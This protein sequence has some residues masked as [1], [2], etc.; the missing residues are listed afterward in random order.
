MYG[1]ASV[2]TMTLT[3]G[4]LVLWLTSLIPALGKR[5]QNNQEFQAGLG[6]S[7]KMSDYGTKQNKAKQ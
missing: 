5:R 1:K 7:M 6:S 2:W 4:R 3:C